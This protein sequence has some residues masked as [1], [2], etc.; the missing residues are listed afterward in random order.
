ME[1]GYNKKRVHKVNYLAAIGIISFF[2]IK[3]I[4]GQGI[5]QF[6]KI[7]S[8]SL[9]IVVLISIT[10]FLKIKDNLKAFLFGFIP[11]VI[12]FALFIVDGYTIDKHYILIVPIVMVALYFERKL[13][14]IHGAYLNVLYILMYI[15]EKDNFLGPNSNVNNLVSVLTMLNGTIIFLYFLNRWGKDLVITANENELM[16]Q[17]T[18]HD[19]KH[20]FEQIEKSTIIMDQNMVDITVNANHTSESSKETVLAVE[21]I[22]AGVLEQAK[23]TNFINE[24]VILISNDITQAHD[25]SEQITKENSLMM[26][27]VILGE[28]KIATMKIQMETINRAIEATVL[29]VNDLE[30]SM[31]NIKSFLSAITNISSQTNLLAL[32]ASIE[33]ARAGEIGKGFAVVA[34]EIRKLAEE[35]GKS[36]EDINKIVTEINTKTQE[37]VKTINNGNSAIVEGNVLIEDITAQYLD[38]KKSFNSSNL[39]LI[40]EIEMIN[41]INSNFAVIYDKVSNIANISEQQAASTEEV[42]ATIESQNTNIQNLNESLHVIDNLNKELSKLAGA[43][44]KSVV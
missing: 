1:Q 7:L 17:K 26:K 4:V 10:Y 22:S 36:V 8:Y 28:E 41:Q 42:L 33:S 25:I 14:V 37:A 12:V 18:L 19:L 44:R 27:Q 31:N 43:D 5:S 39:S 20:T 6:L 23:T 34:N 38:I 9:P 40:K 15:V 21:E 2:L 30:Q 29:T 35:S 16:A 32:N 11:T 24:K 13:T 3:T